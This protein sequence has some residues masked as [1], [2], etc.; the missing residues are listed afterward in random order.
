M[1][2]T[3][4][5]LP[6]DASRNPLQLTIPSTALAVTYDTTVSGATDV[7]LNTA[8]TLLEVTA[9]SQGLFMRY[10]ATAS[11]SN[12]DEYIAAN[13]TRHYV[14]PP[15]VTVVSFIEEAASATLILIEK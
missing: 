2:N 10:Q 1:P 6:Q 4:K 15:S 5:N 13:T 14:K 3:S 7:T 12:F 8:T 9:K 11:S